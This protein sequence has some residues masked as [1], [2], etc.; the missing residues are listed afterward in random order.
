MTDSLITVNVASANRS[1]DHWILDTGATNHV[2]GNCHLFETFHST[3]KGE[4]QVKT[5]NNSPVN[6]E[7]S[8][9]STLHVDRPNAKPAKIF[10][11]HVHY[12]PACG[13]NNL[14]SIIQLMRKGIIFDF[15]LDR[16][17]TSLGSVLVYDTPLTKS[18]FVLRAS[19]ISTSILKSSV[20][21]DDPPSSTPSSAPEISEAYSNIRPAVDDKHIL[22]WHAPLGHLSLPAIKWLLSTVRG[23]QLHA[24]S[25][26]T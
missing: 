1:A 13:M 18:L 12:V 26:S 22:V 17:T 24:K 14:L 19:T 2:A 3:A 6:A 8:G 15:K 16:A 21:R 23:I 5:A 25:P 9:T 7:G 10:L 4:H 11:Q 20:V